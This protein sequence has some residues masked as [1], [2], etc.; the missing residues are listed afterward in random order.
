MVSIKVFQI[1]GLHRKD[2]EEKKEK[3]LEEKQKEGEKSWFFETRPV[4]PVSLLQ[5]HRAALQNLP[6]HEI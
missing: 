5:H 4:Q 3:G 2:T 1:V 6:S